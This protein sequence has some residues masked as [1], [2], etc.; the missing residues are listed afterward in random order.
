MTR[1]VTHIKKQ[2][3]HNVPTSHTLFLYLVA[4]AIESVSLLLIKRKW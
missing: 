3:A 2:L 4:I 1:H